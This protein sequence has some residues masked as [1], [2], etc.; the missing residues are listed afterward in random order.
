ME[1]IS[2]NFEDLKLFM[3]QAQTVK[4]WNGLRAEAKKI[5]SF[6]AICKL[7]SSGFISK[8]LHSN[9]KM[10]NYECE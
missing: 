9:P 8:V 6:N 1:K 2:N 5:F 3:S 4:H 7:D 10:Q